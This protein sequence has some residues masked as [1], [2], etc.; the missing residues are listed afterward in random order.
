MCGL[1]GMIDYKGI[2]NCWQKRHIIQALANESEARGKDATG[3]AYLMTDRLHIYKRALPA[4]KVRLFVPNGVTMVMGHTRLT[5]QGSS[6]D[7]WNNHPFYGKYPGGEFAL[8]HNGVLYNDK[9]L[10]IQEQLP[11]TNTETDSYIAVQLLEKDGAVNMNSLAQMA[12][13]VKDSFSFTILNHRGLYIV[14]GDSPFCLLRFEAGFYLYTS[15]EEIMA[16]VLQKLRMQ[17]QKCEKVEMKMGDILH[18][19]VDGKM[20]LDNFHGD[21]SFDWYW[22]SKTFHISAYHNDLC[23]YAGNFGITANEID[24]LM[25][26]YDLDENDIE[27]LLYDPWTLRSMLDEIRY[28]C[29]TGYDLY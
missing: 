9:Q 5:T 3:I 15:T 10:R 17:K 11:A 6:K 22:P 8:A 23:Q 19:Q 29:Y 25:F 12:E 21:D 1:F 13:K 7:N 16:A 27:Q 2:L 4:H 18:I 28:G 20:A 14:K 24:E 26:S